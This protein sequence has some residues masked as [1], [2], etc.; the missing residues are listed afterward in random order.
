[1]L[2][3]GENATQ[4]HV[5]RWLTDTPIYMDSFEI[6]AEKARRF[7]WGQQIDVATLS[8][9]L[10]LAIE[11]RRKNIPFLWAF[12][13]LA[14]LVSLSFA[15]NLFYVA[16][17]LTPS[18]IPKSVDAHLPASR[19]VLKAMLQSILFQLTDT[20]VHAN[21]RLH[22]PSETYQLVST[23]VPLPPHLHCQPFSSLPGSLFCNDQVILSRYGPR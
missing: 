14:H 12:L 9:S 4:L 21:P 2:P 6:V 19:Y 17:L 16:L 11:G 18:P 10:L 1:V 15:Q 23:P 20:K 5:A 8:W 7:W 22:F 13:A 3:Y